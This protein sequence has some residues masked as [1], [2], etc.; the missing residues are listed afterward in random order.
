MQ[1]LFAKVIQVTYLTRSHMPQILL[2]KQNGHVPHAL[3]Q[4][5]KN[6][7]QHCTP[8]TLSL[9]LIHDVYLHQQCSL[10]QK[11]PSQHQVHM[12]SSPAL[13]ERARP[14]HTSTKEESTVM[15]PSYIQN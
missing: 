9:Q 15:Q 12:A 11:L 1:N 8:Q 13:A 5:N 2:R 14:T 7:F 4:I 3:W 6:I 10:D